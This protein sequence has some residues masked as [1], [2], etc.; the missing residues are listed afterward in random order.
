MP[1]RQQPNRRTTDP[2]ELTPPNWG[3]ITVSDKP[4]AVHRSI[5]VTIN[6]LK[7]NP[8][9]NESGPLP[10]N[11]PNPLD[12]V[13]PADFGVRVHNDW[14]WS[15]VEMLSGSVDPDGTVVDDV[16]PWTV[17][18]TSCME[19]GFPTF[20]SKNNWG[21]DV[22]GL[23]GGFAPEASD[24]PVWAWPGVLLYGPTD[25]HLAR[26]GWPRWTWGNHPD[27]YLAQAATAFKL[28]A[29][30]C[31][32]IAAGHYT[33]DYMHPYPG[34]GNYPEWMSAVGHG[35][36]ESWLDTDNPFDG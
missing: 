19:E 31:A 30:D 26:V 3:T 2:S 13:Q 27:M 28:P 16:A 14:S 15:N 29:A 8:Y 22:Y 20:H 32:G 9:S 33:P 4:G 36:P 24:V 18:L 12:E 25:R 10:Q 1:L 17:Y 6:N 34:V 21:G 35:P 7:S 23:F 5:P 11:R